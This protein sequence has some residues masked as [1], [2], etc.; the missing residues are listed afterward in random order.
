MESVEKVM[1]EWGGGFISSQQGGAYMSATK[2][3]VDHLRDWMLGS[4]HIVSMGIVLSNEKYGVPAGMCYSMPTRCTGDG[5]YEIVES[6]ALNPQQQFRV[7][8]NRE[9]LLKEKAIVAEF[10]SDSV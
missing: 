10:L 1:Y 6:L 9:E 2:A 4:K 7:T 3:I 5:N 8:D